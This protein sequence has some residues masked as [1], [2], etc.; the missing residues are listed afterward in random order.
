MSDDGPSVTG[1]GPAQRSDS[2]PL[3]THRRRVSALLRLTA[4][5][6]RLA[7][8]LSRLLRGCPTVFPTS[9]CVSAHLPPPTPAGSALPPGGAAG[10]CLA[11][12]PRQPSAQP[13]GERDGGGV[14]GPLATAPLGRTPQ[15][16]SAQLFFIPAD[17]QQINKDR[18]LAGR[19]ES[20]KQI[21]VK[22]QTFR[23]PGML[24]LNQLR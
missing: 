18:S 9:N 3:M 23:L 17:I 22:Y 1:E 12:G 14:R 24:F 19:A 10:R 16:F 6:R 8:L 15:A 20:S 5:S 13:P 7:R 4:C 11:A 21:S 2:V